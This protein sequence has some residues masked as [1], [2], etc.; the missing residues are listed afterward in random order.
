MKSYIML[1]TKV[2]TAARNEFKFMNNSVCGKTKGNI[3]DLK[4]MQLVTNRE[5]YASYMMKLPNFKDGYPY[6][7]ELF[8]V[9]IAKSEIS[10]NKPLYLGQTILEM[11]QTL[12]YE[13]H[14]DYM[15]PSYGSK[16]KLLYGHIQLFFVRQ[17]FLQRHCKIVE[18]SFDKSRYLKNDNKPLPTRKNKKA[19]HDER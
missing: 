19:T 5:K 3:W 7:T 1:N 18:V 15:Q 10:L 16:V 4:N 6:P 9:E 11:S 13:F 12:I 17:R 8:V 14:Y 2:R